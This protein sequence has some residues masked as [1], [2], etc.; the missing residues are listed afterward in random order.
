M[1]VNIQ[2]A[3]IKHVRTANTTIESP[4][5]SENRS[6][7]SP[8]VYCTSY[9]IPQTLLLSFLLLHMD[10]RLSVEIQ[11]NTNRNNKKGKKTNNKIFSSVE[12]LTCLKFV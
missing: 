4:F 8:K 11:N 6:G 1:S 12:I 3:A 2:I 9:Q 5:L 7:L 10:I